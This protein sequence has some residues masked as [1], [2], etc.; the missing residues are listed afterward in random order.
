MQADRLLPN[1]TVRETLRYT[2]KLKL[3]GHVTTDDIERKVNFFYKEVNLF[4]KYQM[5]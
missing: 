1:L 2:A 4:N 3:P 5:M